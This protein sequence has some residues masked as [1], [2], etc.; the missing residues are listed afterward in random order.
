MQMILKGFMKASKQVSLEKIFPAIDMCWFFFT[1][2]RV[3]RSTEVSFCKFSLFPLPN[4][5]F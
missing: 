2:N 5:D 3:L 4:T 1:A